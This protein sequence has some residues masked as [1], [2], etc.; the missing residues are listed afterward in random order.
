MPGLIRGVARTAVIS[1]TATAVS[2]R[3]SRRQASRWAQ[4]GTVTQQDPTAQQYPPPQYAPTPYPESPPP[5]QPP[6]PPAQ[7]SSTDTITALKELGALYQQGILTEAEFAAQK[8][9]ILGM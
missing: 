3:V 8:A 4:Q 2:N 9:K 5:P 6:R 7:S 1:G